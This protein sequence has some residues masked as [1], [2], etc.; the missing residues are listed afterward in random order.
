MHKGPSREKMARETLKDFLNSIGSSAN[1]ISYVKKEGR[2]G[3]GKDPNTV[4]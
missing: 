4:E 1:K 2:D 3:L